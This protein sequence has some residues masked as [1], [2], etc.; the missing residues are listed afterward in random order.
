MTFFSQIFAYFTGIFLSLIHHEHTAAT[1]CGE[2]QDLQWCYYQGSPTT[3]RTVVFLHGFGNNHDSWGWNSVTKRILA[4]WEKTKTDRPDVIA[5][6]FG[7]LW[8]YTH[9]RGAEMTK[10]ITEFEKTQKIE[11]KSRTLYGDSMG[12]HNSFRWAVD[13]PEF[14][15]RMAL[16]CPAMPISFAVSDEKI[17]DGMWPFNMGADLLISEQYATLQGLNKNPI[18]NTF[19]FEKLK[20]LQKIHVVV[21]DKDHFGF[22]AGGLRLTKALKTIPGAKVAL[23]VQ[24]IRHCEAEVSKLAPFIAERR[25]Y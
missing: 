10:F 4:D 9:D 24:T 19:Y 15:E 18:T 5:L 11:N 12:G 25:S 6:S 20:P 14:F 2:V 17:Y 13:H 3:T 8:W 23:E 16:I 1:K 22:Y 7:K 21:S